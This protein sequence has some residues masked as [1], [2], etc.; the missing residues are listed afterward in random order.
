MLY[1]IIGKKEVYA[2]E[3]NVNIVKSHGAIATSYEDVDQ[4]K[5]YAN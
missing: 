1:E 3:V 5:V 4:S 2:V